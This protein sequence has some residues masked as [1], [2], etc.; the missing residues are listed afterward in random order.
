MKG[1]NYTK[2]EMRF[3][4]ALC[5]CIVVIGS[6]FYLQRKGRLQFL[7]FQIYDRFIGWRCQNSAED[8]HILI[9]GISESDILND[10][11]GGWPVPDKTFSAL[12]RALLAF[13]PAA[14]GIDVFRDKPVPLS[15]G[16]GF[17]DLNRIL[18]DNPKIIAITKLQK[19][20]E[21]GIPPPDALKN[22]PEQ[23]GFNDF[24][25][26]AKIDNKV[27][28]GLLFV[29]DGQTHFYSFSLRL[30]L[31]YLASLG[32]V[33]QPD[34]KNLAHLK[35]GNTTIPPFETD[36]GAYVNADAHGYQFL[37][38]FRGPSRFRTLSMGE[39]LS[40]NVSEDE[41][42]GKI[43]II[44]V[45]AESVKDYN[46]TPL[47]FFHRGVELHAIAVNQIL[48]HAINGDTPIKV[49][50]ES[51]EIGL[52]ILWSFFGGW[53]GYF[54]RRPL[55]LGGILALCILGLS[56]TT[57]IAF[58]LGWW[59]PVAA[60]VLGSVTAAV[61]VN[62]AVNYYD[63]KERAAEL[64]VSKDKLQEYSR[65]LEV[66]VEQRTEDLHSKNEEL[67]DTL[68]QL[69]QAQDQLVT[70]EKLASLGALTA[71]I[72]HELKNPLNFVT[73]FA[74]LS[75]ELSDE[76]CTEIQAFK[77]NR[78]NPDYNEI[79]I[80]LNDLITNSK[81]ITEHGNRAD[82]IIQAMLTHSRKKSGKKELV[83]INTLLDQYLDLA[84][85][86]NR[87]IDT[88]S[89]VHIVKSY[90]QE[91]KEIEVFPQELGRVFLNVINNAYHATQE[92]KSSA[93]DDYI[94]EVVL[95]TRVTENTTEIRIK[96]N[97]IGVP[98]ATKGRIFEPFFTTKPAGVGTGL[99]LSISYEIITKLHGGTLRFTSEPGEFTEFIIAI[100]KTT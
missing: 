94:P 98:L 35:L 25:F 13:N 1:A 32:V 14:I 70:Q 48:R 36:D 6:I 17:E 49:M 44:G 77:Q 91:M 7:D 59:I 57:W 86:G 12:L 68:N 29:D 2:L 11:F 97:G 51:H 81:K 46:A 79:E 39:I 28:R 50:K 95:T 65:T 24:P 9:V 37:L 3:L 96:D 67:K 83:N 41:V 19:K 63:L 62:A 21:L 20:S 88:D 15:G 71:G 78:E 38:D 74:R 43:V 64:K 85:H 89:Q 90:A 76:L 58:I 61:I 69:R 52:M 5:V 80:I 82:T 54:F 4:Q 31:Q 66:K 55:G 99:G 42:N 75:V 27:R 73:N 56:L 23:I 22:R 45:T 93:S 10:A 72:A 100:P 8:D 84:Y 30:A 60:S 87:V 34:E 18:R 33:T 53:I 26:D 92:K 47:D 40:G 16:E